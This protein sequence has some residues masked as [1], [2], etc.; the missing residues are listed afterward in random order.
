MLPALGIA[1]LG[2]AALRMANNPKTT[3]TARGIVWGNGT[4]KLDSAANQPAPTVRPEN[5][6][7]FGK[8]SPRILTK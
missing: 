3:G 1:M 4:D 7:V 8:V 5:A 6:T 2:L